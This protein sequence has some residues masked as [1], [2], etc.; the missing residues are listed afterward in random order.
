MTPDYEK[1]RKSL[2]KTYNVLSKA[3]EE[4]LEA[5]LDD[6]TAMV[7]IVYSAIDMFSPS[8]SIKAIS[9]WIWAMRGRPLPADLYESFFE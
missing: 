6:D 9:G 7:K 8:A 5:G 1:I 4:L 2:D 3:H